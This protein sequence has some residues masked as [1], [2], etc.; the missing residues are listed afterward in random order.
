MRFPLLLRL[1]ADPPARRLGLRAP[2]AKWRSSSERISAND[3]S[4]A[5]A[6]VSNGNRSRA[7]KV[8]AARQAIGRK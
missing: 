2:E 7:A 1:V 8:R 5:R 3:R 6:P 4:P